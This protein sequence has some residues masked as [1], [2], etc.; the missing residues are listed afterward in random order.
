MEFSLD[1][2]LAQE[3]ELLQI[4]IESA[5]EKVAEKQVHDKKEGKTRKDSI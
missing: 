5:P 1:Q 2:K 4:P 3:L